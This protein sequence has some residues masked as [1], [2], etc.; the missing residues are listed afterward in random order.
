MRFGAVIRELDG[1]IVNHHSRGIY[2]FQK[3]SILFVGRAGTEPARFC[4]V[5]N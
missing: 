1:W 2:T 5:Q 4:S 3:I